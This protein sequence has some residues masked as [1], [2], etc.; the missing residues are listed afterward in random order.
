MCGIVGVIEAKGRD[1]IERRWE[2][3]AERIARRGPDTKMHSFSFVA[4]RQCLMG[5]RRLSILDTSSASNQPYSVGDFEM[6]FN[7]ELY[8]HKAIRDGLREAGVQ[9]NTTGDT[10]VVLRSYIHEG[11]D[12]F[13]SFDG[14]WALAILDKK[15]KTLTIKR[16]FF[17]EKPLYYLYDCETFVFASDIL[18]LAEMYGKPLSIN[19]TFF[20]TFIRTGQGPKD[21]CVFKGV[22]RLLS[23][24]TLVLDIESF[25]I[26]MQQRSRLFERFPSDRTQEFAVEDFEALFVQAL[27]TRIEADVPV[28]LLLSGGIDSSYVALHASRSLG[29]TLN[30]FT[31]RYGK[32]SDVETDRAAM[33]ASQLGLPHNVLD[34]EQLEFEPL[35]DLSISSM[36]EPI[37]DVAYPYLLQ[38]IGLAPESIKVLLTGDGADELFL[39]YVNYVRYLNRVNKADTWFGQVTKA[40]A[41]TVSRTPNFLR[42]MYRK[43][44]RVLPMSSVQML[45]SDKLISGGSV[46]ER[47]RLDGEIELEQLDILYDQAYRHDLDD[48]LLVKSDRASMWNSKELRSPFLNRNLLKYVYSCTTSSLPRGN[49]APIVQKLHDVL[50]SGLDFSKRGMFAG[51]EQ[52]LVARE[53][54]DLSVFGI[55]TVLLTPQEKY[56]GCIAAKWIDCHLKGTSIYAAP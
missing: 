12:C 27:E 3:S 54:P 19:P 28:G 26:E 45:E 48:Y 56:R 6:V 53:T 41:R 44:V 50:G 49:K 7:G 8:N 16:D 5:H 34:L 22:Q 21:Q 4:D 35:I 51:G 39:S 42:R 2:R 40:G 10:E 29:K 43:S 30:C 37:A 38:I 52:I 23:N 25:A 33:V 36:D 24:E 15:Q 11:L 47:T 32:G 31:V 20:E 14:M 18:A 55:G 13:D 17:G 1:G 9:F 46:M